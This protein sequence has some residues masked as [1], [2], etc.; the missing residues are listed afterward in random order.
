[1]GRFKPG[2]VVSRQIKEAAKGRDRICL[3]CGSINAGS[4]MPAGKDTTKNYRRVQVWRFR[5]GRMY[6]IR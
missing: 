3:V 6:V 4:G 1:M 2:T 5:D